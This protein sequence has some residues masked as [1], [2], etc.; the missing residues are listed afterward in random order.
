MSD[1]TA[2]PTLLLNGLAS[3]TDYCCKPMVQLSARL[4]AVPA[5]P[6]TRHI[7]LSY[8]KIQ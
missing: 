8:S 2:R 1:N 3:T 5:K 6:T 7:D 4:A